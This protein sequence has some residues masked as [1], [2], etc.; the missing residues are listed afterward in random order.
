M[1]LGSI[2]FQGNNLAV[3]IH[4]GGIGRN[5]PPHH[6]LRVIQVNDHHLM[7]FADLFTHADEAVRFKSQSVEANACSINTQG[8]QLRNIRYIIY[9][10]ELTCKCSWNL[11][12][13]AS[14]EERASIESVVGFAVRVGGGPKLVDRP[15]SRTATI[16]R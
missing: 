12:G 9:E 14:P 7:L 8:L 11:M 1:V 6:I 2:T 13:N 4:D 16:G 5:R 15:I 3:R 10:N